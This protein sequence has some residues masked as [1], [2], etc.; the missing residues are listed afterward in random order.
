MCK[1][2][3][4]KSALKNRAEKYEK[5]YAPLLHTISRFEPVNTVPQTYISIRQYVMSADV[6][7]SGSS[8]G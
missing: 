6:G 5:L 4:K 2:E 8:Y 7:D 3:R 1:M